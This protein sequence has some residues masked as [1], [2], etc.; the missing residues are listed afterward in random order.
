M[1]NVRSSANIMLLQPR[2]LKRARGEH[3]VQKKIHQRILTA[4]K[5]DTKQDINTIKKISKGE[6]DW[7]VW[8]HTLK[9]LPQLLKENWLFN[10][11]IISAFF[12]GF[13]AGSQYYQGVCNQ[14]IDE[15]ILGIGANPFINQN[16]TELLNISSQFST[17]PYASIP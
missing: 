4:I 6:A 11:I 15:Q 2:R 1:R 5:E 13:Y 12:A 14:F 7:S 10:L 9:N 16:L 3:M 8:K 17:H